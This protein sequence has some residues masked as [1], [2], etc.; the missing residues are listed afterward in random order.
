MIVD[1]YMRTKKY[2]GNIKCM[3]VTEISYL[4]TKQYKIFNTKT[5]SQK[6]KDLR[7]M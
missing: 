7:I 6:Y 3:I 1:G 2:I 4:I 5:S